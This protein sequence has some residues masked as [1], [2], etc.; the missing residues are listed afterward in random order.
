MK[1]QQSRN[2]IY[3]RKKKRIIQKIKTKLNSDIIK[4]QEIYGDL[5]R[6]I[7]WL[8][9]KGGNLEKYIV[10]NLLKML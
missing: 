9:I 4:T 8:I 10:Q 1:Y 7:Y 3:I 6:D 5:S 2:F